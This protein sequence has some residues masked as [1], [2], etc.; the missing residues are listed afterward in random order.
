LTVWRDS[1]VV[2]AWLDGEEPDASTG[3]PEL[4]DRDVGCSVLDLRAPPR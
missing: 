1:W 4:L 3:D 2:L